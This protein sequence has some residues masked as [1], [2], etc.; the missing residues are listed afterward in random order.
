[1]IPLALALLV[2]DSTLWPSTAAPA[3][4]EAD[5]AASVELG[6]KFRSDVAGE[7]VALRFYKGAGNA[8]PHVGNLWSATGTNLARVTF[9]GETASGWQRMELSTPAAV[10][11]GVTYVASVFCPQGRYAAD[12]GAFAT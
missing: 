9:T 7:I 12:N 1:M 5:D 2:Q 4:A 10:A 3:V 11:A 8:G 6:V